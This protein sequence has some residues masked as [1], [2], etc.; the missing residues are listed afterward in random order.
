MQDFFTDKKI[1]I[2]KRSLVPIFT[3]QKGDIMAVGK[4]AIDERFKVD[5][6]TKKVAE[7]KVK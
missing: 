7:I 1:P 2:S 4:L 6:E 5:K 3:N